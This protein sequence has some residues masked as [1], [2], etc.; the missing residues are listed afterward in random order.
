MISCALRRKQCH[1]LQTEFLCSGLRIG[2]FDFHIAL[3]R[4][5]QQRNSRHVW[6]NLPKQL[7]SLCTKYI[8]VKKNPR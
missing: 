4:M 7:N 2:L 3:A 1:G 5:H 8:L 6:G